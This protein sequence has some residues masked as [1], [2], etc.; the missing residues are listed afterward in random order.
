VGAYVVRLDQ[1]RLQ[2]ATSSFDDEMRK[3]MKVA[4]QTLVTTQAEWQGVQAER[5]QFQ[6]QAPYPGRFFMSDPDLSVGQWV[7]KKE[8]L[9]VLVKQGSAW[10]VETWLDEDDVA[11]VRV[12]QDA[13]FWTDSMAGSM[14]K[15]TVSAIDQDAARVLVRRELASSLGGHVSTRDKN[16]QMVPERAIYRVTLD[17]QNM[18]E[19][20]QNVSWRGR[21]TIHAG[22]ASPAGRYLRQALAVVVREAGF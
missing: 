7:A 14:L 9:G 19:D 22:W 18:P 13:I 20:M 2:A 4:E 21:V 5:S 10:R 3:R 6:P 8:S 1:Q 15:L 11:R 17:V 16:G 12:G